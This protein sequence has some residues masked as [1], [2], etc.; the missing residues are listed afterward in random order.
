MHTYIHTYI[1]GQA[2]SISMTGIIVVFVFVRNGSDWMFENWYWRNG[3]PNEMYLDDG[4]YFI[5]YATWGYRDFTSK[6]SVFGGEVWW[7]NTEFFFK[8]HPRIYF[9]NDVGIASSPDLD[10]TWFSVSGCAIEVSGTSVGPIED[11]KDK[12]GDGC[13][14]WDDTARF[15]VWEFSV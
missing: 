4:H 15:R 6:F 10:E 2:K 3:R 11:W 12:D 8:V 7:E 14:F 1:Y 13:E 5:V 9:G